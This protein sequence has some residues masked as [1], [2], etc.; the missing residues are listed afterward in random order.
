MN[1][2]AGEKIWSLWESFS[3]CQQHNLV[4][5]KE[6][7]RNS[8]TPGFPEY[9]PL[10]EV[11]GGNVFLLTNGNLFLMAEKRVVSAKEE[12]RRR[13]ASLTEQE[14]IPVRAE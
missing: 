10:S 4:M 3:F 9:T 1:D 14:S 8:S 2:D 11:V 5:K 12:A 13:F 7:G 6:D